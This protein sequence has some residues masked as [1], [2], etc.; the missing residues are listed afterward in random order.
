MVILSDKWEVN[1]ISFNS[2]L[3]VGTGR[4]ETLEKTKLSIQA[5]NPSLVTVAIRR[6]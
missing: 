6:L 4:F 2:R 3:L 1:K 5:S